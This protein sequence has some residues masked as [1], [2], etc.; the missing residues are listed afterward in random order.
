[1][2]AYRGAREVWGAILSSTLTTVLEIPGRSVRILRRHLVPMRPN[3]TDDPVERERYLRA[4]AASG[5]APLATAPTATALR[6]VR[7]CDNGLDVAGLADR[8]HEL[9][10]G[11]EVLH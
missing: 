2:A 6:S 9:L 11:N 10:V 8:N 3:E 5:Q 1:M 7:V 4:V